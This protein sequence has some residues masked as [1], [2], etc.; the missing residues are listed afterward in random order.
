LS[1][2]RAPGVGGTGLDDVSVRRKWALCKPL[3]EL[4]D[5]LPTGHLRILPRRCRQHWTNE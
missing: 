3:G 2:Q 5:A 4:A 1:G